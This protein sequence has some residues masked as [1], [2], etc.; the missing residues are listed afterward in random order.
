MSPSLTNG[1]KKDRSK[2]SKCISSHIVAAKTRVHNNCQN[3]YKNEKVQNMKLVES[4]HRLGALNTNINTIEQNEKKRGRGRPPNKKNNSIVL[5]SKHSIR[6]AKKAKNN[7]IKEVSEERIEPKPKKRGPKPGFKRIKTQVLDCRNV[8]QKKKE[9][10]DNE[11]NLVKECQNFIKKKR[12]RPSI[13]K[14]LFFSGLCERAIAKSTVNS[15]VAKVIAGV[16]NALGESVE[17]S[18]ELKNNIFMNCVEEVKDGTNVIEKYQKVVNGYQNTPLLPISKPL[19]WIKEVSLKNIISALP[20]YLDEGKEQEDM[21]DENKNQE[22]KDFILK[23]STDSLKETSESISGS[24]LKSKEYE[25]TVCKS[26]NLLIGRV[27]SPPR[28]K[29]E[30][31][32]AFAPDLRALVDRAHF[33]NCRKN[34]QVPPP[35]SICTLIYMAMLANQSEKLS[36]IDICEWIGN[37]FAY[38]NTDDNRRDHIRSVILNNLAS[39]KCFQKLG[40]VNCLNHR[41]INQK[42]HFWRLDPTFSTISLY[43]QFY[44]SDQEQF[45]NDFYSLCSFENQNMANENYSQPDCNFFNSFAGEYLND[46]YANNFLLEKSSLQDNFLTSNNDSL[47]LGDC[48]LDLDCYQQ[49]YSDSYNICPQSNSDD[50]EILD[51]GCIDQFQNTSISDLMYSGNLNGKKPIKGSDKS[52]TNNLSTVEDFC[53]SKLGVVYDTASSRVM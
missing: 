32:Q 5:L 27:C 26:D 13:S 49:I 35:Y 1:S 3:Q 6:K 18:I 34:S 24:S 11:S 47:T 17:E 23:K 9:N 51:Y 22:N 28:C 29:T 20:S 12:G 40:R 45:K 42:S 44:D 14:N 8:E 21:E 52:Y 39:N 33:D 43:K 10:S 38:F 37:N 19:F 53:S 7:T 16:C 15:A 30:T 25:K 2:I 50:L 46:G 41:S 48:L 4:G 31:R 36:D